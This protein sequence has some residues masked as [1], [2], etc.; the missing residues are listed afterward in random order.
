MS[1]QSDEYEIQAGRTAVAQATD[2]RVRSFAGEMI[3]DHTH[4]DQTLRQAVAS[5]GLPPPASVLSGDQARL[6]STL[7]SLRGAEFD[8]TYVRQQVLAHEGALA[9]EESYAGAG[10]DSNLRRAAQTAVPLVQH[11]LDMAQKLR[12]ALGS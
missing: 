9:V 6:L 3:N 10:S 7:Q 4:I 1:A 2:P 12:D 11:H 8:R 5:S